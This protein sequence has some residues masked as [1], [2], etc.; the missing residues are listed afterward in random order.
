MNLDL[1]HGCAGVDWQTVV[2]ILKSVG[3]ALFKK[4]R[5]MIDRG[6]TE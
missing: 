1:K 4:G 3:M 5:S 6:F 2:Q